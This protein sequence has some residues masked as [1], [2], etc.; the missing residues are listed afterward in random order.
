MSVQGRNTILRDSSLEMVE[1][2]H[3]AVE[4]NAG[5]FIWPMILSASMTI[6]LLFGYLVWGG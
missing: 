6:G 3:R 4:L 1:D 5:I 2:R